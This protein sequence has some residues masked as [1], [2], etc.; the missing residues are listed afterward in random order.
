MCYK[1]NLKIANCNLIIFSNFHVNKNIYS[2]CEKERKNAFSSENLSD[3]DASAVK[4][5]QRTKM[6]VKGN[7]ASVLCADTE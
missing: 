2:S 3:I 4:Y 6:Q 7:R 1:Y 5:R